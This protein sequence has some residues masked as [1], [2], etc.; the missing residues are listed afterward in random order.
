ME[1]TK[2]FSHVVQMISEHPD[3]VPFLYEFCFK[4]SNPVYPNSTFDGNPSPI[5]DDAMRIPVI[6]SL[7][8]ANTKA[9]MD[10][11]FTIYDDQ[12]MFLVKICSQSYIPPF[13]T[14]SFF[15][16]PSPSQPPLTPFPSSLV[17]LLL[18]LL[19]ILHYPHAT[20][21]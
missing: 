4:N 5:C 6:N 2:P 11:L 3:V 20:T 19:L 18:L 8:A 9:S 14:F 17:L 12:C 1:R 16:S 21:C 10:V 15:S 13:C 7:S